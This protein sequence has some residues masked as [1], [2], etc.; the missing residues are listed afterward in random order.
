MWWNK[1][2]K[3]TTI[4]TEPVRK[5]SETVACETCGHIVLKNKAQKVTINWNDFMW[6]CME[7]HKEYDQIRYNLR[8]YR[9]YK[10]MEVD[11]LGIPIGYKKIPQNVQTQRPKTTSG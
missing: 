8:T 11:S 4:E 3:E 7:H 2:E 6:Y 9:Y 5:E 10:E 1:I